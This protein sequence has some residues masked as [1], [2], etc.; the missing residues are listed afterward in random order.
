MRGPHDVG[1]LDAGPVDTTTHDMTFWERE[2]DALHALVGDEKRGI[3][4]K[5]QNRRY[6]FTGDRNRSW[7]PRFD[8]RKCHSPSHRF[9]SARKP[10]P[11]F[12]SLCEKLSHRF[13]FDG[14][15]SLDSTEKLF[16]DIHRCSHIFHELHKYA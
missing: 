3:V 9:L 4:P 11:L 16:G 1:G 12:E 7:P 8:E 2:I 15:S 6:V 5:G 14:R 13:P 10:Q